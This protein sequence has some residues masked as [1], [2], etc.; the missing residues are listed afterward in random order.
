MDGE[1]TPSILICSTVS[2]P[3]WHVLKEKFQGHNATQ[4]S[5]SPLHWFDESVVSTVWRLST[6]NQTMYDDDWLRFLPSVGRQRKSCSGRSTTMSTL[7]SM[8]KTA[9]HRM[10]TSTRTLLLVIVQ[11]YASKVMESAIE[12]TKAALLRVRHDENLESWCHEQNCVT[13][14]GQWLWTV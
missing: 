6:E 11:V 12:I 7:T 1:Q 3:S 13:A 10:A 4:F 2:R 5:V 8:S 9:N 14:W